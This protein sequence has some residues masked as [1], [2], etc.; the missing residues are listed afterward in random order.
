MIFYV[1]GTEVFFV[2]AGKLVEQVGGLFTQHVDQHVQ[3]A[4]VSHTQHHFAR[5]VLA[6]VA[7]HLFQHGHQRIAAFQREAFRSREFSAEIA[8][9]TF[10][11][12]QLVQETAFLFV[13]KAGASR[14]RFDALLD[15]AFLFGIGDMHVFRTDRTAVSL[16]QRSIQVAQL[17]GFFADGERTHVKGFLEVGVGQIVVSGIEVSNGLLLPQAER[18]EIGMLMP[19]ETEGVDQLQYLDLFGVGV[20]IVDGGIV[21]RR[22]FRQAAEVVTRLRVKLIGFN[23]RGW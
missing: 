21:T 7:N 1:T 14:Y 10:R 9:Q 8:F 4:A 2:L 23:T 3:T 19:A 22:V 15:P 5:A 18:I 13:S 6:G 12:G 11:C 16:L 20:W 17:H